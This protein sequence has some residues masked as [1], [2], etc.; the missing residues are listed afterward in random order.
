MPHRLCA[1]L[2]LPRSRQR[3]FTPFTLCRSDREKRQGRHLDNAVETGLCFG[4][5]NKF[6]IEEL[7]GLI[8]TKQSKIYPYERPT[9]INPQKY[10]RLSIHATFGM[11]I[12]QFRQVTGLTKRFCF[13]LQDGRRGVSRAMAKHI[14]DFTGMEPGLIYTLTKLCK[15]EYARRLNPELGGTKI[16]DC[17]AH[18]FFEAPDE[19]VGCLP[20]EVIQKAAEINRNREY[21]PTY[22]D[23]G[24]YRVEQLLEKLESNMLQHSSVNKTPLGKRIYDAK[25]RMEIPSKVSRRTGT[26][27]KSGSEH[28][29]Q[30]PA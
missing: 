4:L 13:M 14:S 28:Q 10:Y 21:R 18:Y 16:P 29:D 7:A 26:A 25:R 19:I 1:V 9:S 27:D 6:E 8:I 3:G 11:P 23:R 17:Y 24:A 2:L 5:V 20:P 30:A 22:L 12:S 15:W